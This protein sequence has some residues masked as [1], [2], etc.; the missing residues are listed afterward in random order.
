MV[1]PEVETPVSLTLITLTGQIVQ[2]CSHQGSIN[3]STSAI[4][5]SGLEQGTY[6]LKIK[7]EDD[8][9]CKKVLIY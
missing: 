3:G 4:D 1:Q 2:Q 8:I 7:I 5:V 9:T 6:I